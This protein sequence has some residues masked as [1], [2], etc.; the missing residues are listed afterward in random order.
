VFLFLLLS[1]GWTI[2]SSAPN[3]TRN[4]THS[5][6]SSLFTSFLDKQYHYRKYWILGFLY[7]ALFSMHYELRK[8][9]KQD[10]QIQGSDAIESICCSTCGLAQVY[11]EIV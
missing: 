5:S 1:S 10:K 7:I 6:Y 4:Q 2:A 8:R 9:V 3:H 11:R